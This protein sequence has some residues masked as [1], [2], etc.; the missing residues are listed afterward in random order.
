MADSI[1]STED[2]QALC[3][4]TL[5]LVQNSRLS[6]GGVIAAMALVSSTVQASAIL[7]LLIDE[8]THN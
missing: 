7:D 6:H 2:I 3:D 8:N 4:A 5:A 1:D